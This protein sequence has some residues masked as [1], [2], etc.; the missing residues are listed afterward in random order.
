ME[1]KPITIEGTYRVVES[2]GKRFAT[3]AELAGPFRYIGPFLVF[4]I[5]HVFWTLA[6]HP[7]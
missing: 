3:D 4:I 6:A 7:H 5:L 1:K 2:A